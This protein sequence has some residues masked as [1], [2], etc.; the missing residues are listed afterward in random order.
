MIKAGR[1]RPATLSPAAVLAIGLV[2]ITCLAYLPVARNS[3]VLYDDDSYITSN[4]RIPRGITWDN[5]RWAFTAYH[6]G[7]W[8]P[9]T[10]LSHLLDGQLYGL[11]PTGHHLTSLFLHCA[12]TVSLFLVFRAMTGALWRSGLVAALFA[13][14]PLHVESVA[15]AS[16]RKDVLAGF[17]WLL[18]MAAYVRYARRPGVA[19]YLPV[20]GCLALGLMSKAL[21]VTLPF[22]LLLLDYWPLGR[23]LSAD[24]RRNRP[25]PAAGRLILEKVPLLLLAA[26]VSVT[27]YAAQLQTGAMAFVP[28]N[29]PAVRVGRAIDSYF[30]Y[31]GKTFWPS[32][33]SVFYPYHM[34]GQ[35]F[36]FTAGAAILAATALSLR[37]ALVRPC[38]AVGWLWFLGTL[39]PMIGLVQVGSQGIADRY[40][41]IPL[42][43]IFILGAWG[44]A[45]AAE[46]S[47]ALRWLWG[48]GAAV[49]LL[50]LAGLSF[51]QAGYWRS[52]VTLFRHALAVNPENYNAKVV[53][54]LGL[55]REG[56]LEEAN[57]WFKAALRI[58]PNFRQVNSFIAINLFHRGKRREA[59]D[60]LLEELRIDPTNPR[61]H[62]YLASI[63]ADL[64]RLAEARDHYLEVIRLDPADPTARTSLGLLYAKEGAW[65]EALAA[66]EEALK[67]DPGDAIARSKAREARLR[68]GVG[69][70][71]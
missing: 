64:G 28:G 8:H 38:L 40:T 60:H 42:I 2:A 45:V 11:N 1:G 24:G 3:F 21:T 15:W 65:S 34:Q 10:L 61:P 49:L 53:L 39:V 48:A 13:I 56:K 19:R 66:F 20:L 6:M 55:T 7:N 27:T 22:A 5:L 17:F 29:T 58:N 31:L 54:G 52:T 4:P 26:A 68:L 51:R 59:V 70:P 23:W 32:E 36:S 18:T 43:G 46:R 9:L 12:T 33:L 63:L 35:S 62:V 14:H 41:Y 44:L 37:T 47:T 50:A 69:R 57:E 71:P 67:I 16:E 25:L 30:L